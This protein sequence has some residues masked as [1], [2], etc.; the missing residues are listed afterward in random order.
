MFASILPLLFLAAAQ[1]GHAHEHGHGRLA[2]AV[3]A[4]GRV[5]AEFEIP[6]DSL[7]GFE[8]EARTEEEAAAVE[9]AHARLADPDSLLLFPDRA[10]CRL[11][12]AQV[13]GDA[14]D[15]TLTATFQCE[16]T[17]RIETVGTGIFTHFPRIEEIEGILVT[18][19][20][21]TSFVWT[22]SDTEFRLP[23]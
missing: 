7:Y 16:A 13:G 9:A 6:A 22:P 20:V 21:Q 18:D 11:A 17:D 3:S 8:R 14:H 15:V 5:E 12:S 2:I 19:T 23:R 1:S 4:D 10:G